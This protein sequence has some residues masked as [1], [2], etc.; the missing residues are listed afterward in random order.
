MGNKEVNMDKVIDVTAA[1][2]QLGTLLDEVFY[3]KDSFTIQRKGKALAKIIPM[4]VDNSQDSNVSTVTH[5]QRALLEEMEGLPVIP[6][7]SN[8]ADILRSIR[9]EKRLKA[10]MNYGK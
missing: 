4:E 5:Q 7:N 8:P 3:K 6:I 1:R 9:E 2:R 10:T